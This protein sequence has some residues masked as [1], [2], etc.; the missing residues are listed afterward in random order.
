V[1]AVLNVIGLVLWIYLLCLVL[2]I[3]LDWVQHFARDWRPTGAV[4]VIAETVY[5]V[6]DPP[7][8]LVRRLIPPLRLGNVA[9]DLGFML[10]FLVVLVASTVLQNA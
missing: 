3:V 10:V 9:L 7:L 2:R 8:R 6:T 4:L 1:S 5:T